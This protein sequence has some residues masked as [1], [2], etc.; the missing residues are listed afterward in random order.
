MTIVMHRGVE[1]IWCNNLLI[2]CILDYWEVA[3]LWSPLAMV[4]FFS[5]NDVPQLRVIRMS[6]M[7][8]APQCV[9]SASPHDTVIL[10]ILSQ[11]SMWHHSFV[12]PVTSFAVPDIL[13]YLMPS[14]GSRLMVMGSHRVLLS[15]LP[16]QCTNL[17]KKYIFNVFMLLFLERFCTMGN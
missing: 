7:Y 3:F 5:V 14:V 2:K 9:V 6:Y 10:D 8:D 12:V 17:I 15:F 11:F 4:W 1:R 16:P 13:I